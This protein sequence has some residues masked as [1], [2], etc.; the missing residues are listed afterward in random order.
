MWSNQLWSFSFFNI[1][2]IR[3]TVHQYFFCRQFFPMF[4]C[5][6]IQTFK[7]YIVFLNVTPKLISISS[8]AST[9]SD[10]CFLLLIIIKQFISYSCTFLQ[11]FTISD[12]RVFFSL[13]LLS[14]DAVQLWPEGM[15]QHVVSYHSESLRSWPSS[16]LSS[17]HCK[18]YV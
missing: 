4:T 16:L 18:E 15:T 7:W 5:F 6:K 8:T 14:V 13:I 3:N 1:N 17:D 10:S 2:L 9:P 12:G 11:N